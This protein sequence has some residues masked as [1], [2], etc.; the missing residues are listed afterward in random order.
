MESHTTTTI[1]DGKVYVTFHDWDNMR[2]ED[3]QIRIR[4]WGS[5]EVVA[6]VGIAGARDRD[7]CAPS[8]CDGGR[9]LSDPVVLPEV[10]GYTTDVVYREGL[11]DERIGYDRG[12]LSYGLNPRLALTTN[13]PTD[14]WEHPQ[15]IIGSLTAEDPVTHEVK[16]MPEG[17]A[18]YHHYSYMP[19][20][21]DGQGRFTHRPDF[22]E[23]TEFSRT[24]RFEG[25][26][27]SITVK[28]LRHD[29][30]L[31]VDGGST[32]TAPAGSDI[33]VRGTVRATSESGVDKPVDDHYVQADNQVR[34]STAK[35]GSFAF[36]QN[37]G[38]NTSLT[39]G[40][41]WNYWFNNEAQKKF[42]LHLV[43]TKFVS[44]KAAVD[45]Y[46]KVTITGKPEVAEGSYPTGTTAPMAVQYSSDGQTWK[47]V[48]SFT[49]RYGQAFSRT[50]QQR[51]PLTGTGYW[52]VRVTKAAQNS[53]TLKTTR[54]A[55]QLSNDDL[56]PEGVKA[57]TQITAKGGLRQQSG[58]SWKAFAGQK[59]RV[60]F[61][62]SA[63][64]SA[65]EAIASTTTRTDGTFSTKVTARQDG[66]WQIRY[67]DTPATHY[68]VYGRQ[69]YVDVR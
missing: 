14:S 44:L 5:N 7:L 43:P 63:K 13:Y 8:S 33:P 36:M 47:T 3:V 62:A 46:R 55:T 49:G 23:G 68:A 34:T 11:P 6:T 51:A 25:P 10:R 69:D 39:V 17:T 42:T 54:K 45:K 4:R 1:K 19:Q 37:V 24:Y 59:V 26:E 2:P 30:K 61:K 52:R 9:F 64:G 67:T 22:G 60:Y 32:I 20:R 35:D 53:P 40:P 41:Q 57:G 15:Q 16:P 48:D 66:T 56:T 65:W 38:R 31:T 28:R 29:L 21:A 50:P 12:D 18:W 58:T 27:Q